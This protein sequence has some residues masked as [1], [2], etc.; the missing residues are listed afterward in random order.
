MW[1]YQDGKMHNLRGPAYKGGDTDCWVIYGKMFSEDKHKK[2]VKM[3]YK[4]LYLLRRRNRE[5]KAIEIYDNTKFCR[6]ISS[7]IAEYIF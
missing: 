3:V 4:S 7:I 6:D 5:K 2:I 1:W